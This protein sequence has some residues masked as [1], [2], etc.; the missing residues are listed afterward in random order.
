MTDAINGSGNGA[1]AALTHVE[2]NNGNARADGYGKG[3][4]PVGQG[5]FADNPVTRLLQSSGVMAE[6]A[7]LKLAAIDN[8]LT[9]LKSAQRAVEEM[10]NHAGPTRE[11][12]ARETSAKVGLQACNRQRKRPAGR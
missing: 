2:A 11:A 10:R 8:A 1:V 12:L 5:S 7:P 6:L 3:K 4:A 9:E